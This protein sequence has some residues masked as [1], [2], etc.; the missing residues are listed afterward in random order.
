MVSPDPIQPPG[1]G[2]QS[3]ILSGLPE[4]RKERVR[5][6]RRA[7]TQVSLPLEHSLRT[8]EAVLSGRPQD[9]S[10]GRYPGARRF[11][12]VLTRLVGFKVE[13]IESEC[14]SKDRA[15][16]FPRTKVSPGKE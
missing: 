6:G 13:S 9:G 11:W 5:E 3:D 15:R 2:Q 16:L 12:E 1:R 7:R 8:A 10:K 14:G 4:L